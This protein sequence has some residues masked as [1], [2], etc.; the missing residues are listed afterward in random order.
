M[1]VHVALILLLICIGFFIV[2][3]KAS[4]Y[5]Y[6]IFFNYIGKFELN[7]LKWN[8]NYICLLEFG[9]IIYVGLKVWGTL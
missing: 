7:Y 2:N 6:F 1:P 8:R 5:E 9:P 3:N 4:V